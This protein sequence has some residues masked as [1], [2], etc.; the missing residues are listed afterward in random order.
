MIDEKRELFTEKLT[1]QQIELIDY[2]IIPALSA[3]TE[4]LNRKKIKVS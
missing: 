1:Q 3:Y 4:I 2:I